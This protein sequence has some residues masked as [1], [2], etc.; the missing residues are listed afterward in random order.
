MSRSASETPAEPDEPAPDAADDD[1]LEELEVEVDDGGAPPAAPAGPSSWAA[2]CAGSLAANGVA[3]A[4]AGAS[5]SC[6][7]NPMPISS[8][9]WLMISSVAS[10]VDG[11]GID[12]REPSIINHS[13]AHSRVSS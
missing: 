9:T 1:E 11:Q 5:A 13:L 2:R 8:R 7:F 3:C 6:V 4:G 12:H 10:S